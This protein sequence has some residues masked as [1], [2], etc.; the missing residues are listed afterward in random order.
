[1]PTPGTT[2]SIL[3]FAIG[4]SAWLAPNTTAKVFGLDSDANPQAA[5]LARLFGIRDVGLAVSA[6]ASTGESKTLAWQIG[7]ACDLFDAVAAVLGGRNGTL[8]KQTAV[9][10]GGTAVLAA[11][12]GVAALQSGG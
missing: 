1:M 9:M 7:I 11:G 8:S 5:Y 12:L 6:N 2:L 3:R 10:A 4:A